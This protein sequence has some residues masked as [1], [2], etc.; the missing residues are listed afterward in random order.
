MQ[1]IFDA[2]MANIEQR[3]Q[4]IINFSNVSSSFLY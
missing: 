2:R 4:Q 1:A 3:S